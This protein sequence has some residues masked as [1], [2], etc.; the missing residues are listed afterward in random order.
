MASAAA[1][2][3]RGSAALADFLLRAP[4]PAADVK[5][6]ALLLLTLVGPSIGA[7]AGAQ[8]VAHSRHIGAVV[9]GDARLELQAFDDGTVTASAGPTTASAFARW[10]GD[11]LRLWIDTAAAVVRYSEP[12]AADE[13]LTLS[14]PID[15]IW[16]V[17]NVTAAGSTYVLSVISPASSEVLDTRPTAAQ[18]NALLRLLSRADTVMRSI[19]PERV[20]HPPVM[21]DSGATMVTASRMSCVSAEGGTCEMVGGEVDLPPRPAVASMPPPGPPSVLM[22]FVVNR[23][24]RPQESSI[25]VLKS[26][27]P[28]LNDVAKQI[29]LRT[30]YPLLVLPEGRPVVQQVQHRIVFRPMSPSSDP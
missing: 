6:C 15:G 28:G 3:L 30:R 23:S 11:E 22:Q 7:T 27:D 20:L 24:G 29:V 16:I 12:A 4:P 26:D 21:R 25:K 5:H 17:R 8:R 18:V 9:V 19:T 14:T 1:R 10:H 13:A 2:S